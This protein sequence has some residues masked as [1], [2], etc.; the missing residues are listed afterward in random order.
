MII[1]NECRD[2]I[3]ELKEKVIYITFPSIGKSPNLP[4]VGRFGDY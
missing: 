1:R 4:A 2:F 3:W